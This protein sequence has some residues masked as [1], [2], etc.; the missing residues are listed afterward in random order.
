MRRSPRAAAGSSTRSPPSRACA[1][2]LPT[3]GRPPSS[4][5]WSRPPAPALI[6]SEESTAALRWQ[7]GRG[8]G[9]ASGPPP[10]AHPAGT[11]LRSRPGR[12]RRRASP[13][14]GGRASTPTWRRSSST[15]AA[16]CAPPGAVGRRPLRRRLP[17]PAAHRALRG[18]PRARRLRRSSPLRSCPRTTAASRSGRP[19]S[20]G[21]LSW[22]RLPAAR[23]HPDATGPPCVWPSPCASPPSRARSP[24]SS[25]WP[26]PARQPHA[27][28]QR[29]GR[30]LRARPRRMCDQVLSEED[31]PGDLRPARRDGGLRCRASGDRAAMTERERR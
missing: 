23:R 15:S 12:P 3:R 11:T 8:G 20:P 19:L 1:R 17:E 25:R 28:A 22:P 10:A 6:R 21:I 13:A 2:P 30:R 29:S 5:R 14:F 27:A 31:D 24:P 26:L 18:G 16:G 9:D 4:W 7:A